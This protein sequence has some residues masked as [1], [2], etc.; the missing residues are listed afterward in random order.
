MSASRIASVGQNSDSP[1]LTYSESKW[2]SLTGLLNERTGL[3]LQ[4]FPEDAERL[5]SPFDELATKSLELIG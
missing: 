1:T 3:L 4:V 5:L 2:D